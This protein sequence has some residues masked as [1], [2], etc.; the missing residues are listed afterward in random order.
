MGATPRARWQQGRVQPV[1]TPFP[2]TGEKKCTCS[3]TEHT[4]AW[5][6]LPRMEKI[7]LILEPPN[8]PLKLVYGMTI[9][10]F[11]D[12]PHMSDGSTITNYR[13][14]P[15]LDCTP[16]YIV[17]DD[18]TGPV[19]IWFLKMLNKRKSISENLIKHFLVLER[20]S[21]KCKKKDRLCQ[22]YHKIG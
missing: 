15:R 12:A 14:N 9:T 21:K 17:S 18:L 22:G 13:S 6:T 19:T 20:F 4:L 16:Q 7:W 1:K 2:H 3:T 11:W 10:D 8:L 5:K